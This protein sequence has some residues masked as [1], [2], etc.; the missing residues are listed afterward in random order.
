MTRRNG[1]VLILVLFVMV[2][3]S[4]V[5]VSFG[6]RASL[7]RRLS[8]QR[9]VMLRLEHHGR[10][11][12]A[13]AL[14]RLPSDPNGFV[15]PAQA[16]CSHGPL[17]Q[18]DWL[19]EWSMAQA[20]GTGDYV[21]D[22]EVIDEEGKLHVSAASSEALKKL[23]MSDGQIACLFDW[24]DED[25]VARSEGAEDSRYTAASPPYHCKNA[26]LE[27]LGELLRIQGFG[28]ED[29]CVRSKSS[30]PPSG[31]PAAALGWVR[32]LTVVGDGRI[33]INTSPVEVLATL[34]L[35][36]G[37]P[38]QI[39]AYR[40]FTPGSGEPLENHAFRSVTD[41]RQLQGLTVGD[42]DVLEAISRFNSEHFRVI[43]HSTHVPTGLTYRLE[44]LA[45]IRPP[46]PPEILEQNGGP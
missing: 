15:H 45:R 29:Y 25:D 31:N 13:I 3:L 44:V 43:A 23:G 32:L 18:E 26:P 33:N 42:R 27:S 4:L 10:S 20:R 37:A 28:S 16:W 8:G 22:Y 21:T 39:V 41:V 19:P 24:I 6:Y 40:R 35:S 38:E 1:A 14:A 7:A 30:Q 2:V 5:A 9:A 34:P 12:V 46:G 17:D 11:A 36:A